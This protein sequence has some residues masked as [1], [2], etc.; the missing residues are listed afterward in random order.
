MRVGSDG[1][2]IILGCCVCVLDI[3]LSE[4]RWVGM[5]ALFN[6]ALFIK[7]SGYDKISK[8]HRPVSLIP[9]FEKYSITNDSIFPQKLR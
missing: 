3:I 4:N 1:W 7:K 6:N 2:D 9:T 5:D 8:N